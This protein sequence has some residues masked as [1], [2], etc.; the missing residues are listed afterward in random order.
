MDLQKKVQ[1]ELK[2]AAKNSRERLKA[3]KNNK[4]IMEK[5]AELFKEVEF[6][7]ATIWHN[8]MDLDVDDIKRTRELTAILLENTEIE[9]FTKTTESRHNGLY[10]YYIANLNGVEVRIGPALPDKKC[11]V[12]EK[13]YETRYWLCEQ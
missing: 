13:T 1:I 7:V 2:D 5:I 6:N 9:K 11:K 10:W 3:V 12:V 4:P 8:R